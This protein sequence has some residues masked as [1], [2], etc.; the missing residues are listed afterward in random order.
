M[1]DAQTVLDRA[2]QDDGEQPLAL[3]LPN[4]VERVRWFLLPWEAWEYGYGCNQPVVL[5]SFKPKTYRQRLSEGAKCQQHEACGV[6]KLRTVN[7]FEYH[8]GERDDELSE[9]EGRRTEA[10]HTRWVS[11]LEIR[12]SRLQPERRAAATGLPPCPSCDNLLGGA[13]TY[14]KHGRKKRSMKS[15]KQKLKSLLWRTRTQPR[16]TQWFAPVPR[17]EL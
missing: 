13:E 4:R 8:I 5:S 16:S 12:D 14:S 10:V 3:S 17:T 1:L 2:F 11:A 15:I 6:S 9:E 7:R